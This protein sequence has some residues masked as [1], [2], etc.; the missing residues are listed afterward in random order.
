[1]ASL[2]TGLY[3]NSHGIQFYSYNQSFSP[4]KGGVAPGLDTKYLTLA[5]YFRSQGYLTMSIVS[6]PWIKSEFGF[7][8]GFDVFKEIGSWDGRQINNEF[9]KWIEEESNEEPFFVYLH[10][11]DVHA[12][13]YN[14]D[15][16]KGIYT[17]YKGDH[18]CGMGFQDVLSEEDLAY[19]MALYDEEINY[20]DGLIEEVLE[21]LKD[22]KIL[23]NT[24]IVITSDHGEEFSEHQGMGHGTSLYAEQ[25]DTFFVLYGPSLPGPRKVEQKVKTID[26][27]P[28]ILEVFGIDYDKEQT[29]GESLYP[30]IKGEKW[31][32]DKNEIIFSELGD[33]KTVLLDGWKYIYNP[34]LKTEELYDLKK[35]P[36]EGRNLAD[37]KEKQ[38]KKLNEFLGNYLKK[39]ADL[40]PQ[41]IKISKDLTERLKSLGY[42]SPG[43]L[44]Q[45]DT[46]SRLKKPITDRIDV[47]RENYNPLQLVFGWKKKEEIEKEI[48]YWVGPLA[49]FVLKRGKQEQTRLRVEGRADLRFIRE[50]T[51]KFTLFCEG[52]KLGEVVLDRKGLFSLDFKIP[53]SLGQNRSLKF[54]LICQNFFSQKSDHKNGEALLLSLQISSIYLY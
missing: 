19:S 7:G 43:S 29:E 5:E 44:D 2:F 46:P 53:P 36:N 10:Y 15:V 6:N 11:M 26:F 4:E 38:R 52:Y 33:I 49:K 30:L 27:F 16:F 14:P 1:M 48:F 42:L 8:Q 51:Q 21:K 32:K 18:I 40:S 31:K 22:K 20:I 35:D 13:Y 54:T 23:E 17:P 34:V 45:E 25:I 9:K 28:T 50:E 37:N 24:M 47:K 39:D 3:P 12:P 41:P